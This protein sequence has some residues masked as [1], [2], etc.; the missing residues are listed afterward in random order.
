[1]H[2]AKLSKVCLGPIERACSVGGEMTRNGR[3]KPKGLALF[4]IQARMRPVLAGECL[5]LASAEAPLLRPSLERQQPLIA[6]VD[7]MLAR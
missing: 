6:Q 4:S 7:N 5:D 2:P 1:M 3:M